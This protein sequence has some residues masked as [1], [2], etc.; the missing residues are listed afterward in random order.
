MKNKVRAEKLD[1]FKWPDGYKCAVAI[2]WHVDGEAGPIAS[3]IRN[4]KHLAALSL[5]QYGV[6]TAMPRILDIHRQYNIPGSFFIPGYVAENHPSLLQEILKDKHEIAYHGYMHEN[7]FLLDE[8][9]EIAV[10]QKQIDIF[11]KLI[12]KRLSGWSAP[13][14]GIRDKTVEIMIDNGLLYDSSLM[15]YDQ[16]YKITAN[17]NSLIELPISSVLD[18]Y[19]IFYASLFPN[20]GGL[21]VPA[22]DALQI[23]KEEFDGLR[24]YGGLFTTTF[25]PCILGRPGRLLM[26]KE[27]FSYFKSFDDVWFATYEEIAQYVKDNF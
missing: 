21:T 6:S 25:H 20:G 19:E 5:A 15:E 3:D 1:N 17:D 8:E 26:L 14:W 22:S 7:V 23:Y 18:D 4:Q 10:M 13:G 27:L 11:Q 2:G 24:E 16:P 12:G 9:T